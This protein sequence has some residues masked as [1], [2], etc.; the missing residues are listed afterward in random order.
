MPNNA[1]QTQY[2]SIRSTTQN[3]HRLLVLIHYIPGKAEQA[4]N[5]RARHATVLFNAFWLPS[6]SQLLHSWV[7][8]YTF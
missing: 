8:F 7:K 4:Y 5:V 1:V 2:V 3:T 6:E